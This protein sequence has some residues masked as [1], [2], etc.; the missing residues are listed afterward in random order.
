MP[1]TLKKIP[2]LSWRPAPPKSVRWFGTLLCLLVIGAFISRLLEKI[3]G[4]DHFWVITTAIPAGGWAIVAFIRLTVY[5]LQDIYASAWD[6]RREECILQEVRRGRRALQVLAT[7]FITARPD[8]ALSPLD[9]LG[10]HH[11]QLCAQNSWSGEEGCY[12]TRLP[13]SEGTTP[14]RLLASSFAV[15]LK[16]LQPEL[17]AFSSDQPVTVLLESTSSMPPL[18]VEEYW[19]QAWKEAGLS[20]PATYS[21]GCGLAFIDR[22]LDYNIRDNALLLVVALQIAPDSPDMT[23]E[24][25]VA[26]LLGNRLT[27]KTLIP[28][29]LL[30]RP[31]KSHPETLDE[32]AM[33]ALDW[34]PLPENKLHHLWLAGLT[35]E[36][37][38]HVAA[39]TGKS[40]LAALNPASDIDNLDRTL[41]HAGCAAPW[42]AIAAAAQSAQLSD[43]AHMIISSEQG[44]SDIWSV[45]VA[46]GVTQQH[47]TN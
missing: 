27:Q 24:A 42:L 36:Q 5:L 11:S 37:H 10:S 13:V 47:K 17:A 39:L 33:Q 12:H 15:L 41:G 30:H 29:A 43:E 35:N 38:G 16:A 20:L 28:R 40:P 4:N 7:E 19:R 46:P 34:V 9:A 22:W 32:G 3:T 45:V 44:Q 26:L 2:P 25:V 23:A 1:V 21:K 31:E 8:N 6:R 18:R 14:E